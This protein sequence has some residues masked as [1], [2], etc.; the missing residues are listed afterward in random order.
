MRTRTGRATRRGT[1]GLPNQDAALTRAPV[2]LVADGMGGHSWGKLA[3]DA[4]VEVFEELADRL[5]PRGGSAVS[6]DDVGRAVKDAAR[7]VRSQLIWDIAEAWQHGEELVAGSTV[8]GVILTHTPETDAQPDAEASAGQGLRAAWLTVNVG[9]S[10]TY[11]LRDG[12]LT[13]LTSDH[14]HV[15]T[16]VDAGEI[17]RDEARRHPKRNVITRAVGVGVRGG[18]DVR[19]VP[20]RVGDRVMACSDGAI[21]ALSEDDLAG[22]LGQGAEPMET[23]QEVVRRACAAGASDDVTVV[24]VDAR[25]EPDAG[26]I[27][28]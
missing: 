12:E 23:A 27:G 6:A 3:S 1:S 20:A 9:D 18:P 22:I 16:L 13:A 2:F 4:V 28:R 10:R 17:T 8:S 7:S 14:S 25:P 21:E 5:D 26:E 24:V 19:V 15:Q 11:L